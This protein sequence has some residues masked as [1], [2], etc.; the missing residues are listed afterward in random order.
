MGPWALFVWGA[1]PW[2]LRR[3]GTL[4]Q[5]FLANL[6]SNRICRNWS[7]VDIL[8]DITDM[9]PVSINIGLVLNLES[10]NISLSQ[11][12]TMRFTG[13]ETE[14]L[15]IL[16][17]V[18]HFKI[19]HA[20]KN[21]WRFTPEGWTLLRRFKILIVP[22]ISKPRNMGH[23]TERLQPKNGEARIEGREED[24]RFSEGEKEW[25]EFS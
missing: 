13:L 18:M 22:K 10:S 25:N 7:P 4:Y 5:P 11:K 15:L 16:T 2:Y 19:H 17:T 24:D 6:I 9:K 21:C 23:R 3:L 20:P 12:A 8:C 1:N 14:G